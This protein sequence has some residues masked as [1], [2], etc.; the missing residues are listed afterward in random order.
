MNIWNFRDEILAAAHRW[1]WVVASFLLGALLGWLVSFVWPAPYRA[2]LN[3]YV[4]LNAYRAT[5]DLYIAEVA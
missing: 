2:T 3:L 4:G 1:Y 5:R